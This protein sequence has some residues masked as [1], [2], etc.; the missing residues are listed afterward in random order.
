M[1]QSSSSSA[2][3]NKIEKVVVC[4]CNRKAKVVQAWTEDNPGRRFYSCQGRKVSTG[5]DSCNFF[6]WYDVEKPHG[7][8]Y[9]ALLGA[10]DVIRQ[11]KEEINSLKSQVRALSLENESI[12]QAPSDSNRTLEACE[13]LKGEAEACEALKGEVEALKREV[14]ILNERSM[15]YR[16]VLITSSIGFTVVIGVFMGILKW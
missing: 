7:W 8:Q 15:V 14:L 5:Y 9:V 13:T 12:G 4:N 16:N 1:A 2:I 11:Q 10:R 6:R 3:D